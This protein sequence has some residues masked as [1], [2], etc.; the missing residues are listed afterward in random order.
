MK[1]K[2]VNVASRRSVKVANEFLTYEVGMVADLDKDEDEIE[3]T[4][5]LF[6]KANGE[7]DRQIELSVKEIS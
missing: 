2:Q 1:V 5:A 4:R 3:V 7:V 6:E